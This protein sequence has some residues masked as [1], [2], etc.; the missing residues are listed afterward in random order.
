[1]TLA[2]VGSNPAIPATKNPVVAMPTGLYCSL[3]IAAIRHLELVKLGI[4]MLGIFELG[5]HEE[6][7]EIVYTLAL[8][9]EFSLYAVVAASKWTGGNDLIFRIAKHVDS[10]GKI[11]AVERLESESGE[12]RDWILRH[13][14][15]NGVMDAYLGL[16]CA[17][18]G[19]LISALR[20]DHIDGELFEGC[21]TIIDALLDE[22]PVPG[23]SEYEHAHEALLLH[24]RNMGEYASN[25]KHLWHTL[26]IM[27]WA[28][29]SD[30]SY[31]DEVAGL[32]SEIIDRPEW[33]ETI[34]SALERRDDA[35]FFYACNA[36]DRMGLDVG[37]YVLDAIRADPIK[38]H[39]Y[40][41][42]PLNYN[43]AQLN[44]HTR[45][46]YSLRSIVGLG[47]KAWQAAKGHIA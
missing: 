33:R 18:K 11:H 6:I 2:F 16:T 20:E 17:I 37:S 34:V 27:Q 1:M 22:G 41:R 35:D 15:E 12:I 10:W 3:A 21:A 9:D 14:C 32:C 31:S 25:L 43:R 13:G 44:G 38:H 47:R 5:S 28:D 29:S 42:Q 45:E 7:K 40:T 8:Y 46:E 23:I 4:S 26:N 19:D 36:A 39:A 30:E 24:I